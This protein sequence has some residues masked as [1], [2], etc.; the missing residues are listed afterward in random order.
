MDFND[1]WCFEKLRTYSLT[2][3]QQ[4]YTTF[5]SCWRKTQLCGKMNANSGKLLVLS[6]IAI[7]H[8]EQ[9]HYK[10]SRIIENE[11]NH[12]LGSSK[13]TQDFTILHFQLDRSSLTI[14]CSK[15]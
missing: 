1:F 15:L 8:L 4:F 14:V 3:K 11:K 12:H 6:L 10:K 9:N 5:T 7:W 2:S 13:N